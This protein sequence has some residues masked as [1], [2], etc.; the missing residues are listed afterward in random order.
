MS[1]RILIAAAQINCTVGDLS[2]NAARI[3]ESTERARA[4]RADLVLTPELSLCGYPPEDLVLR[5]GFLADCRRELEQ[6][7]ARVRGVS[8][9]VGFP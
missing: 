2:G 4:A 8:L 3:L 5:E 7:A 1:E 6:L 9:V